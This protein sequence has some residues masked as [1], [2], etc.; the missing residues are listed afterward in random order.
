MTDVRSPATARDALTTVLL[1]HNAFQYMRA[2]VELGLFDYL[3]GHPDASRDDIGKELNLQERSLDILLLGVTSLHAIDRTELGYRNSPAIS[4]LITDGHWELVK[5]VVGF[6][7]YITYAGLADFTE[8]LRENRNVGLR[9]FPGS[10]LTLYHRLTEDPELLQ[11]FYHFMGTWSAVASKHLIRYADFGPS[12]S[13][14]DI[15][16]GDATMAV[17]VAGANPDVRVTVLELAGVAELARKR[18]EAAGLSDRVEA[19]AGDIFADSY[20]DGHDTIMFVH[21][22]QIW[23]QDRNTKLLTTAYA[24]LPPGGRVII[25][26]SMSEDTGDGP[27]MAALASP[28]FAAVAGEGGMIYPWK[29]YEESLAVAGFHQIERI[30]CTDALTPHGI[31]V[32]TK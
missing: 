12:R 17:A 1:G 16:G 30:R 3:E 8:S 32:A 25:M 18:I 5:A 21:Q 28:F 15:G 4:E 14:L 27:L 13:V 22:L 23:P 20:P 10:G 6:E 19:T 24:A 29:K 11:I 31:I 9:R 7:A 2:G 26:N